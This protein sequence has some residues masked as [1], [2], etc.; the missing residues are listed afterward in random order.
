MI[1][2][3]LPLEGHRSE[4]ASHGLWR[5]GASCLL[6]LSLPV[7]NLPAHH[8]CAVTVDTNAGKT[9]PLPCQFIEDKLEQELLHPEEE[10]C[11]VCP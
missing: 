9:Y 2:P 1:S 6:A 3:R 8:D 5:G 10:A 4:A 11:S 7:D